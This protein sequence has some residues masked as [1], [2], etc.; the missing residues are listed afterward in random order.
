MLRKGTERK[1]LMILK[2]ES[3]QDTH[4]REYELTKFMNEFNRRMDDIEKKLKQ[5]KL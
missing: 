2:M 3:F 1:S 4:R 5:I